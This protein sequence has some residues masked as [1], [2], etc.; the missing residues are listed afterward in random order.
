[1]NGMEINKEFFEKYG[2][3]KLIEI[4]EGECLK[5]TQQTIYNW[6]NKGMPTIKVGSQYRYDL[7]EVM[8]W[9]EKQ[10]QK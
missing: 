10:N 9:M 4:D 1:M 8:Q 7:K 3:K 6:R 2:V 5:V